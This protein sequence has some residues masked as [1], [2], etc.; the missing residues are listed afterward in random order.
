MRIGLVKLIRTLT[1]TNGSANEQQAVLQTEK[2]TRYQVYCQSCGSDITEKGGEVAISS[3]KVYCAPDKGMRY[4]CIIQA[5]HDRREH[6]TTADYFDNS[7]L[8][9]GIAKGKLL[10]YGTLENALH[11]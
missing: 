6:S 5:A 3:G 4:G 10:H 7:Q 1:R 9:E 2:L 11:R 8:Q